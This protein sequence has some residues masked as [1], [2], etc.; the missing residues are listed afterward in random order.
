METMDTLSKQSSSGYLQIIIGPMFSGK[1]TK[2]LHTAT[3]YRAIGKRVLI[4]NHTLNN[5]YSEDSNTKGITTHDCMLKCSSSLENTA[6]TNSDPCRN[7]CSKDLASPPSI[8]KTTETIN[9]LT[10]SSLRDLVDVPSCAAQVAAADVICIEE[11]QFYSATVDV[12]KHLVDTCH[13]HVVCAGLIADYTRSPFGD[14]LQLIPIADELVH[15]K[16]L[17]TVCNDGTLGV[18][19]QRLSNEQSQIHVGECNAYRTVCRN[20]YNITCLHD[21][22]IRE[23]NE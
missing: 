2:L 4:V 8:T 11:L 12:I 23:K 21:I 1:S 3:S 9:L 5:R 16:A 10:L 20:H 7:L 6:N 13:K 22:N 19:T 18:F 17:C 15:L 14:I